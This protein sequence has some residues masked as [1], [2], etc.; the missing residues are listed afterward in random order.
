MATICVD[1]DE[2]EIIEAC[3]LWATT[4]VLNEGR[5]TS[6]ELHVTVCNGAPTGTINYI[7]VWVETDRMKDSRK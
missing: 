6:A 1:L 4:R 3:K 2:N 5:A 7:S